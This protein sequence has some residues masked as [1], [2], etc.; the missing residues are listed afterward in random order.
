MNSGTE[1]TLWPAVLCGGI[2]VFVD[3]V[4]LPQ[5]FTLSAKLGFPVPDP[6][7]M[8]TMI[9]LP[10]AIA[11][12]ILGSKKNLMPKH[13]WAGLPVQYLILVVFAGPISKLYG[14]G[15]SG[16][17]IWEYI[18]GAT[19]W[20]LGVTASQFISLIVMHQRKSKYSRRQ[21]KENDQT[22]F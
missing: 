1:S 22:I 6:I 10:V 18:W 14:I 15:I 8:S 5:V 12:H 21:K 9:L 7:W 17:R 16:I 4:V 20:P 13:V 11:L 2:S 19:V 3:F